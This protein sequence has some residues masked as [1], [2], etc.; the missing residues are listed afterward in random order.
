MT[1]QKQT[2]LFT[3]G[4]QPTSDN[5]QQAKPFGFRNIP[6]AVFTSLEQ[7]YFTT[8]FRGL[9]AFLFEREKRGANLPAAMS[10]RRYDRPL[11]FTA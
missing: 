6:E 8:K 4:Q 9:V 1:G 5:S 2:A 3:A 11:L 7:V 10:R